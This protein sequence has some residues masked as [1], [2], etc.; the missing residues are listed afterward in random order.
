VTVGALV[1]AAGQA[2]RMG[3]SKLTLALDGRPVIAHVLDAAAG[4]GLPALVVTGAHAESVRAA[5]A[6]TRTCH[7]RDH[8]LGM[9]H[10][11]AAGIGAVPEDWSGA[12]VLLGDMPF[13]RPETLCTLADALRGGALAVVPVHG[14]RRGNPAGFARAAYPALRALKGDRGGAAL[15]DRLDA[16]A[17]PVADPGIHRDI[18]RPED[19]VR[20]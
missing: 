6:P 20:R 11:I 13:V 17:V 10:S 15:L 5:I 16:V 14:N 4:A 8:A 18:D 2:T 9:G 19:L 3:G 7:A 12:L 1:L